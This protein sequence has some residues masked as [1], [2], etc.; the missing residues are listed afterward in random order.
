[1]LLITVRYLM[2]GTMISC[3]LEEVLHSSL[4]VTKNLEIKNHGDTFFPYV[5][6]TFTQTLYRYINA[7]YPYQVCIY[8]TSWDKKFTLSN[9]LLTLTDLANERLLLVYAAQGG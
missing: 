2:W 4:V 9:K 3:I 7:K 1:M 8:Y 6:S 5:E